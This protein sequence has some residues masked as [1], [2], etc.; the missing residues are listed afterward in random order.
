MVAL[1]ASRGA[2]FALR[3]QIPVLVLIGLSLLALASG[4][5]WGPAILA[6]TATISTVEQACFWLIFAVFFPAVTG[7]MAGLSMS[8]DLADP[9]RSIPHGSVAATFVGLLVHLIVP[10]LLYYSADASSLIE[11]PLIWNRIA[12]L[13]P[14]LVLPGLWG[15][16]F[17]SAVGSML[18]APRTLQALAKDG[19]VPSLLAGSAKAEDEPWLGI[20]FTLGLSLLAVFLGDLNTVATVATMFSLSVYGTVNL[21]AALESLSGNPS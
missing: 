15:A 12:M 3:S 21:V 14:W 19:L 9:R 5:I 16:I 7:I 4:T 8:G 6:S 10:V 17:S 20:F 1:L 11:D 18:G 2:S 13:G